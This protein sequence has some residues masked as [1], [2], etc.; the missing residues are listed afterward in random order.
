MKRILSTLALAAVSMP[1]FAQQK[2]GVITYRQTFS[3][4]NVPAGFPKERQF[5]KV[6][7]FNDAA[8]LYAENPKK[9]QQAEQYESGNTRIMIHGDGGES[10]HIIYTDLKAKRVIEQKDFFQRLFLIGKDLPTLKWKITGQQKTVIGFPCQE[11]VA[12]N[13]RDTIVAWFT[14][15]IP[16]SS[17]PEALGGLPGMI[18]EMTMANGD[19]HMLATS[20]SAADNDVLAKLKAPVKGKKVTGAEYQQ[21][22][23][24]KKEEMLKQ[25][26][27]NG[28]VIIMGG[29]GEH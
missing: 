7:Y 28:G 5:E 16:V 8:S 3:V 20:V 17:G 26:G 10:D 14:T 19:M 27:K 2:S 9:K 25:F 24:K 6:L 22:E 11:A 15:S 21:M 12:A 13:E 29:P 4:G 1:A 23:T 18:L